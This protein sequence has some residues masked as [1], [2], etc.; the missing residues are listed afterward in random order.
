[1]ELPNIIRWPFE[2]IAY[3]NRKADFFRVHGTL[4][5]LT[6]ELGG[7]GK[8]SVTEGIAVSVAMNALEFFGVER[9]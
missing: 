5:Q 4:Y 1:M 8:G 3:Y 6:E 7:K 2:K 9:N